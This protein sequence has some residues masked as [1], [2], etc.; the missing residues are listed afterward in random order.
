MYTVLKAT[1]SWLCLWSMVCVVCHLSFAQLT[2]GKADF[3]IV[4][5]VEHLLIHNEYQQDIT[6]QERARLVPFT[7][8]WIVKANDLLSDGFTPC[9]KVEI[10]GNVF[11]ILKDMDAN[12]AGSASLGFHRVF[13]NVTLLL[14]TVQV[15]ANHILVISPVTHSEKLPL[16][17]GDR[18]VR[19]F[20]HLNETYARRTGNP[21]TY[22]WIVLE[23]NRENL[24][25]KVVK[26][27]PR[28]QASI[29]GRVL[30]SVERKMKEANRLLD[31]LFTYFNERTH[32]QKKIPHWTVHASDTTITCILQD[33]RDFSHSTLYVVRDLENIVLGTGL[34]VFSSPGRIEIR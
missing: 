29:D 4:E 2:Q 32:Q 15:L 17:S 3:L 8:M 9:M 24:D 31:Q 16:S 28:A 10:D 30:Q 25:W 1:S 5:K 13:N 33:Y 23:E 11:Y 7:P 12:L 14:D 27:P 34:N 22:G 21:P 26:Q 18:I 19:I 20:R 6:S